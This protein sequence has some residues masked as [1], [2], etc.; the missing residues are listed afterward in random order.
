MLNESE[1]TALTQPA[2]AEDG[3]DSRAKAEPL[4]VFLNKDW[5]TAKRQPVCPKESRPVRE[6]LAAV[7]VEDKI[8]LMTIDTG[9]TKTMIDTQAFF[10]RF[11]HARPKQ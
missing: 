4:S 5:N 11:P 9:S 7:Y 6:W 2:N 8:F 3:E 1:D 10:E